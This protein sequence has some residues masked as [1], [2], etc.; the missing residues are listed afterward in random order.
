MQFGANRLHLKNAHIEV[1][2]PGASVL[3]TAG[4]VALDLKGSFEMRGSSAD[5]Y[6]PIICKQTCCFFFPWLFPTDLEQ[7]SLAV[8]SLFAF[9]KSTPAKTLKKIH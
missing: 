9:G 6:H 3:C 5:C 4:A 1:D 8:H 7:L 2:L